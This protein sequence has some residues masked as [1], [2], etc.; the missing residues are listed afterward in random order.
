MAFVFLKVYKYSLFSFLSSSIKP[1]ILLWI[2]TIL[3]PAVVFESLTLMQLVTSLF[4]RCKNSSILSPEYIK[5]N[6]ACAI[7]FSFIENKRFIL[8]WINEK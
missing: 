2:G 7:L 3:S 4:V 6:S 1:L 5:I 8:F